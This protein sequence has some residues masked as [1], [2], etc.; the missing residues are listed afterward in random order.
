MKDRKSGLLFPEIDQAEKKEKT[1]K[2]RQESL[3]QA[4]LNKVRS[5]KERQTRLKMIKG[6]TRSRMPW[7][8]EV[9]I[10]CLDDPVEEIRD[11]IINELGSRDSL[12]L[13]LLYQR[14]QTPPW[15]AKTGC[16]KILGLRRASSSIEH[17][18]ALANDANVEVRRTLAITLGEIGT[19]QALALLAALAKDSSLFVRKTAQQAL[20]KVSQ[21]KFC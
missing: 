19:D 10:Q 2:S 21:L 1:K 8:S 9:L 18:E 4:A 12:D 7:V 17:V 14:L 13:N 3:Y 11:F 5:A 20:Q 16:L 15:F 6:I